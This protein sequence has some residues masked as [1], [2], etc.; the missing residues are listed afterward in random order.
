MNTELDKIDQYLSGLMDESTQDEFEAQ[1]I[2]DSALQEMVT[3]QLALRQAMKAEEDL[4][5]GKSQPQSRPSSRLDT[6]PSLLRRVG[7]WLTSPTWAYSAT[8]MLTA[9]TIAT[10]L[11]NQTSTGV[12]AHP[13]EAR[14]AVVRN[15]E[16]SRSS[17]QITVIPAVKSGTAIVLSIDAFGLGL[18]SADFNL[19]HQGE[20]LVY[21][22]ELKPNS[23]EL[24]VVNIDPLAPGQYHIEMSGAGADPI[25][26]ALEV[27]K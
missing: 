7:D 20:R 14:V 3:E 8:A 22:P 4:L 23:D 13:F 9:L 2:I 27:S 5:V 19:S 25:Q 6:P 18:A 12:P 10:L 1:L 11:P 21:L 24:I 26:F 15:L 17:E 16:L